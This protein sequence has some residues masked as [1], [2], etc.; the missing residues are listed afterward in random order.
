MS[1][2]IYLDAD[3]CPVKDLVYKVATRYKVPLK[4]AANGWLKLPEN[5]DLDA[6]MIV[7]PGSPDAA[8]DWIAERATKG[9][10]VLTADIPLAA[11]VIGNGGRCLD[12][13]GSEFN[14]NRIGD[15]LASRDLN[16]HLRSM[17]IVTG[18]P[19]AYSKTD[20]S[21]FAS[22]LDAAVN[23]LAREAARGQS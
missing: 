20:R 9:D 22:A 18:G 7:V 23:R 11:R 13:R 8:D 16:A 12:F 6:E 14:P 21:K 10:L 3:A 2:I 17:G 1:G 15:A 4:V 5:A 19:S